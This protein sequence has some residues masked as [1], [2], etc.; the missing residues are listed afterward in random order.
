ME[1]SNKVIVKG[2]ALILIV[3]LGINVYRTETMNMKMAQLATTVEQLSAQLDSLGVVVPPAVTMPASSEVS[4]KEFT[5]LSKSV[6][7]LESKV[8]AI[9]CTIDA[10]SISRPQSGRNAG[11]SGSSSSSQVSGSGVS[12]STSGSSSKYS[13]V[14][15]KAKVKVEDR[16]VSG[17]LVLPKVS[18]GPEG[19]VVIGVIMDNGGYVTS[20]RAQS[21]SSIK[22]EDIIDACKEAALKTI[23]SMNLDVPDR[24]PA[25]ITYTFTAK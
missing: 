20:A 15:V 6:N 21:T 5:M 25:T 22:D 11:A 7:A 3:I 4:K 2:L 10:L 9:Q 12:V 13:R 23:F 8:T 17:S 14:S 16:Y 19:V 1:E 18:I 24:H